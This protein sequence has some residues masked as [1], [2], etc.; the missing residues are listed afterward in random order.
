MQRRLVGGGLERH[1]Q[2]Q[3]AHPADRTVGDLTPR[4]DPLL[5]LRVELGLAGQG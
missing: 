3:G 5:L 1:A 2:R 4:L